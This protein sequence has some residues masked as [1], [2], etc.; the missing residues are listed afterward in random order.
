MFNHPVELQ[1]KVYSTEYTETADKVTKCTH[2]VHTRSTVYTKAVQMD[3]GFTT[4]QRL[5]IICLFSTLFFKKIRCVS[6]LFSILI[7]ILKNTEMN[8]IKNGCKYLY[9]ILFVSNL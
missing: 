9:S 4:L 7:F 5:L 8:A 2:G 3:Y 6:N 1:V